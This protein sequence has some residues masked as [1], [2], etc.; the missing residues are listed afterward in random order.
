MLRHIALVSLAM[1]ACVAFMPTKVDAA[2]LS[3]RASSRAIGDDIAASPGDLI[4]II[5]SLKLDRNSEYVIPTNLVSYYDS[6]EVYEFTPLRWLVS[7]NRPIPFDEAIGNIDIATLQ[8]RV[9]EPFK[10]TL[11]DVWGTLTY[12]DSNRIVDRII[13]GLEAYGVGPDVVPVPEPL[14][15]FGTAIGLGCGVLFKRKSS[16]KTV[17]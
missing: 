4:D 9:E 2:T 5:F 6:G 13:P 10:D 16:K 11:P 15:M 17:S 8:L 3:I 7:Q 1:T 12:D 14:T